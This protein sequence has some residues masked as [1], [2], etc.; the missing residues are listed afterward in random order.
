MQPEQLAASILAQGKSSPDGL[1]LREIAAH[2]GC[3][4]REL[5]PL[6]AVLLR[7]RTLGAR[8]DATGQIRFG[9]PPASAAEKTARVACASCG[10]RLL[11]AERACGRLENGEAFAVLRECADRLLALPLPVSPEDW[12]TRLMLAYRA[13]GCGLLLFRVDGRL[14]ALAEGMRQALHLLGRRRDWC[15]LTALIVLAD[16]P[17]AHGPEEI[18]ALLAAYRDTAGEG[19]TPEALDHLLPGL[20]HFLRGEAAAGLKRYEAYR[21]S[22]SRMP[23]FDELFSL[24]ASTACLYCKREH[25]A[26]GIIVSHRKTAELTGQNRYALIWRVQQAFF[27]LRA[28]EDAQT[29][30]ALEPLLAEAEAAGQIELA[31]ACRRELALQH[32]LQRRRGEARRI[33]TAHAQSGRAALAPAEPQILEMIAELEKDGTPVPGY[34]LREMLREGERGPSRLLRG[35]SL[36]LLAALPETPPPLRGEWLRE[37]CAELSRSGNIREEL[38]SVGALIRFLEADKSKKERKLWRLREKELLAVWRSRRSAP[39]LSDGNTA[40]PVSGACLAALRREQAATRESAIRQVLGTVQRELGA[41]RAALF[42][43][44]D[45]ERLECLA[46]VNYS[47]SELEDASFAAVRT[48]LRECLLAAADGPLFF[49]FPD[50]GC[51]F[52]L[53]VNAPGPRLLYLDS[54]LPGS[55]FA[56]IGQTEGDAVAA[57]LSAE[58][59]GAENLAPERR[60]PRQDE[61]LPPLFGEDMGAVLERAAGALRSSAPVIIS[62]ESGTGKEELARFMHATGEF[63]GAFVPVRLSCLSEQAFESDMFGLEQ[64]ADAGARRKI[65]FMEQARQGVLFLDEITDISPL[66]QTRLLRALQEKSFAPV[67]GLRRQT[68][69]FRLI[70]ATRKDIWEEVRAGRFREDLAYRLCAISLELPPLRRRPRDLPLLIRQLHSHFLRTYRKPEK[71]VNDQDMQRLLAYAW[72]GNFHELAAIMEQYV[73][74]GALRFRRSADAPVGPPPVGESGELFGDPPSLEE[75]ERRHIEHV[76]H[77][78]RGKIY[79]PDGAAAILGMK[80]STLYARLKKFGLGGHK[81]MDR[82]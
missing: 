72:P 6:L 9:P 62:G 49:S 4:A 70:S 29:D 45:Q 78:T 8:C 80:K 54:E 14:R 47:R 59:R 81:G 65:G 28:G 30:V 20:L 66:V 46:A 21:L 34:A 60:P 2:L 37:S 44:G 5:R 69:D 18:D 61:E 22:P 52:L 53:A 35:V 10:E 15:R 16:A 55:L 77:K 82:A 57:V 68:V 33:L 26:C 24:R 63:R 39:A 58:F 71:P 11:V 75:V 73:L 40:F 51:A 1:S 74:F 50:N 41:Q 17:S 48:L 56:H 32:F 38:L 36:R 67:G 3:A 42:R 19:A 12:E 76:L 79:G 27:L 64:E 43:L 31:G 23:T 13:L 25:A 7:R